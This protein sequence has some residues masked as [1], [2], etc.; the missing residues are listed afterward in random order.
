VTARWGDR[1][2]EE[3]I[4]T[5]L[6]AG[7]ALAAAIVTLGGALYLARHGGELPAYH[8]F[9]GEPAPLRSVAGI[10]W[11]ALDLRGSGLIQL[12]L[13]VLLATPVARV[14]FAAYAFARQRDRLYVAVTLFVLT[15]LLY[16]IAGPEHGPAPPH[17]VQRPSSLRPG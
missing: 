7:V 14:A 2:V 3:L 5:L 4:G 8:V 11:R 15:V 16:S 12:G 17:G 9:R 6:R 13:L 1:R 10:L